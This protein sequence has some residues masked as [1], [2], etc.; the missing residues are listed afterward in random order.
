MSRIGGYGF[1][2]ENV[3][4]FPTAENRGEWQD[5]QDTV[6]IIFQRRTLDI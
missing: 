1:R 6:G 5:I 3:D 2:N 4:C